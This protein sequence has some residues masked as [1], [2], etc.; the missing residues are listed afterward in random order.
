ML[1]VWFLLILFFKTDLKVW[2]LQVTGSNTAKYN[3]IDPIYPI[4]PMSI[5][6]D[7]RESCNASHKFLI[8]G[9]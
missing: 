6:S 9:Y 8:S 7:P 5:S 3:L 4:N 2:N 1:S